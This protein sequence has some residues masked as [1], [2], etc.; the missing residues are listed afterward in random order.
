MAPTSRVSALACI[1]PQEVMP[2]NVVKSKKCLTFSSKIMELLTS[3]HGNVCNRNNCT[4]PLQY[5]ESFAEECL[6]VLIAV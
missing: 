6:K 1:A 2:D 4:E 5:K 3:L